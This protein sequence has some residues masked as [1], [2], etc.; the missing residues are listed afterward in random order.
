MTYDLSK[1]QEAG[2][3]YIKGGDLECTWDTVEQNYTYFFSFCGSVE[4][5]AP[6]CTNHDG[7]VVQM[8]YAA[9]FANQCK[10]A[11]KEETAKYALA[12]ENDPAAGFKV[13]YT[14]GDLCHTN[15]VNRKTTVVALCEDALE[16][17][18][19]V[20]GDQVR[21]IGGAKACNYEI[22]FRSSYAC[23]K[24]CPVAGDERKSCGGNG[25]CRY[26]RDA[27]AA[28]CFCSNGWGGEDCMTDM[29]AGVSG[30][31][32]GLT[33]TV[34]IFAIILAGALGMLYKQVRDY[35]TDANKY[36]MLRGQEMVNGI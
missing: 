13:T 22:I 3:F 1:L 26:D 17:D 27:N 4:A 23:P 31:I 10:S 9:S 18:A 5:P 34:T 16:L 20:G 33:V 25:H 15:N 28:R 21:E 24:E 12:D 36:L 30:T 8:D 19:R 35:R 7:A 29:N 14:N 11:G 6:S 32:V 2:P